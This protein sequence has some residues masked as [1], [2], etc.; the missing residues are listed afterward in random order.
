MEPAEA[1][2]QIVSANGFTDENDY[3]SDDLPKGPYPNGGGE[4][5]T[6]Q[7]CDGCGILLENPL[8]QA[9]Y[10]LRQREAHRA[11]SRRE[12]QR[13]GPEGLGR[14]LRLRLLRARQR[15]PRSPPVRIFAGRR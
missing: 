10:R 1:L 2:Q 8:T 4:A 14:I 6:P 13:R 15:H 11:R 5:D 7:Y 9:G 12:R 3:D